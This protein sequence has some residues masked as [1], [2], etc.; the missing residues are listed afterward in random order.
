MYSPRKMHKVGERRLRV[1]HVRFLI[2]PTAQREHQDVLEGL[3]EGFVLLKRL[4]WCVLTQ[5]AVWGAFKCCPWA[6]SITSWWEGQESACHLARILHLAL[7][8][9]TEI[10]FGIVMCPKLY[11]SKDTGLA[12]SKM[13]YIFTICVFF[14][15]LRFILYWIYRVY[16]KPSQQLEHSY[17]PSRSF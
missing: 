9:K 10:H 6:L 14:N 17:I 8:I 5:E 11:C 3:S 16:K 7:H 4:L 1:R 15:R 2:I 13:H 12:T